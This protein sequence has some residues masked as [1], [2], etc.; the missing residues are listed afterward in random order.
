MHLRNRQGQ[1]TAC[2]QFG[3]QQFGI[4]SAI[5]KQFRTGPGITSIPNDDEDNNNVEAVYFHKSFANVLSLA[6]GIRVFTPFS[7]RI[8]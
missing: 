4:Y 6:P 7:L 2:G 8:R 1:T 3:E 5:R